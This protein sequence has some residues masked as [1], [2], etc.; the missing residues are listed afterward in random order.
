VEHG[1]GLKEF[2]KKVGLTAHEGRQKNRGHRKW[3]NESNGRRSGYK[4]KDNEEG[5]SVEHDVTHEA[6]NELAKGLAE[7]TD[8]KPR[9][10]DGTTKSRRTGMS[11]GPSYRGRRAGQQ[12]SP[13]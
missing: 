2:T 4:R 6:V 11:R 5:N 13:G 10:T 12:P 1:A 8:I 7:G 9:R 3:E